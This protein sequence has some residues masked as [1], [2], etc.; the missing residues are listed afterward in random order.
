V[1]DQPTETDPSVFGI[2]DPAQHSDVKTAVDQVLDLDRLMSSARFVQRVVRLSL[3]GDLEA[4]YA[5]LQDELS[6][7][8]DAN[9]DPIADGEDETSLGE[10]TRAS[11]IAT[12]MADLRRQMRAEA[13]TVRFQA[14]SDEEW[15]GF[16]KAHRDKSGA[17]KDKVDYA[18]RL[19]V[20]CAIEPEMTMGQVQLLRSKLSRSQFDALVGAAYSACTTGGLDVP[21]LPSFW[22]NPSPQ[23]Q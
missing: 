9:G 20:Q 12:T 23:E 1:T 17:A 11:E 15:E 18:C 6:Q 22:R 4:E 14:M 13:Y 21:K 19:L 10:Q 5:D 7:L 3:R 8:V 2:T 16:E